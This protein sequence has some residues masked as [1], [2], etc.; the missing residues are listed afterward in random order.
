MIWLIHLLSSFLLGISF[1]AATV[2]G[3]GLANREGNSVKKS[4]TF[5]AL[6]GRKLQEI[7]N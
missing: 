2:R 6:P 5:S 1:S 7:V 3:Y 4:P